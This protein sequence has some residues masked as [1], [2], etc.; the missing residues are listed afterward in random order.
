MGY[1]SII[2][3]VEDSKVA[4]IVGALNATLLQGYHYSHPICRK[5]FEKLLDKNR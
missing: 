1:H 4:D 2:E 5:D 3:G